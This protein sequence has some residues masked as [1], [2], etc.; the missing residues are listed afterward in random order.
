MKEKLKEIG[1]LIASQDNRATDA[2]IFIVQQRVRFVG[3]DLDHTDDYVWIDGPNDHAEASELEA[4]GLDAIEQEGGDTGDWEKF[5]Y[6]DRW[7][8]VTACFTE[9]G[10][11]DYIAVNGHNL[12]DPRIYAD[13]SYRN[14]EFRLVREFLKSL[15]EGSDEF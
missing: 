1:A 10:C 14:A 12:T 3:V 11:K 2:P 8:F 6:I 5:G 7:E 13:G 9:Q 4:A 15:A